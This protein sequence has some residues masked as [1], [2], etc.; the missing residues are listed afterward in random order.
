MLSKVYNCRLLHYWEETYTI[1]VLTLSASRLW[2]KFA[3]AT[4][5]ELVGDGID[6]LVDG[7]GGR[8]DYW[9]ILGIGDDCLV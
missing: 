6:V 9:M 4:S 7:V 3:R 5:W 2:V 8:H 1:V